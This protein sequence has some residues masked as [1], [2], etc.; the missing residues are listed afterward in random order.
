MPVENGVVLRRVGWEL[1]FAPAGRD[2]A[3]RNSEEILA[4]QQCPSVLYRR[5]ARRIGTEV[6]NN[7]LGADRTGLAQVAALG[8]MDFDSIPRV[9]MWKRTGLLRTWIEKGGPFRRVS[10]AGGAGVYNL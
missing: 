4:A 7:T 5:P 1:A 3:C 6:S 8:V 9:L 2:R 10:A